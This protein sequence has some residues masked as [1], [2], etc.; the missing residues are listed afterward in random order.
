MAPGKCGREYTEKMINDYLLYVMLAVTVTALPGPAVI[1]TVRNSIKYGYR[2]AIANILGN[3]LAM[4][5]LAALAA[6]GLGVLLLASSTLFSFL[7][8]AGCIYLVYLGIKSWNSPIAELSFRTDRNTINRETALSVFREGFAVGIAN[9]KAIVFFTALFPQFIAPDR[10]FIPQFL[11]LIFTIEG[12]SF[13]VLSC[14][15][16]SASLASVHVAKKK[17]MA[18]FN[19]LTGTAFVGYGLALLCED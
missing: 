11:T 13:F 7:K 9:P 2:V 19:K 4:V 3:F 8:I 5:I 15:A 10:A 14:Y 17:P 18:I 12:I 16:F 6:M 1:L